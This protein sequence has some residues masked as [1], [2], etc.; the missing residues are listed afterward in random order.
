M[1]P[2]PTQYP[3]WIAAVVAAFGVC[4]IALGLVR[5]APPPGGDQHARAPS[6]QLLERHQRALA[7]LRTAGVTGKVAIAD[8]S[9]G[10]GISVTQH[11]EDGSVLMRIPE[12]MAL[13]TGRTRSCRDGNEEPATLDCQIERAVASAVSAKEATT[14]T[15]LIVLLVMERRRG[16]AGDF[17]EDSTTDVLATFPALPWQRDNGLF[18]IDEEEFRIFSTGTSM[19]GWRESAL[20]VV[21]IAHDFMI[22]K[23]PH[24]EEVKIDEVRWAYLMLQ[25]HAQWAEEEAPSGLELPPSVL[26]LL[27]L[28]LAR[29]TPEWQ[30][31][32][33]LRHNKEEGSY[34]VVAT[35]VMRPGDEVHYVDRRL[36]DASVLSFQGLWLT[37]RHRMRLTL[38]VSAAKKDPATLPVLQK[39]GCAAQPLYL[40]VMQQK[41]VDNQFMG[42]M[43]LLALAANATRL[44]RAEK[45]G[46]FDRWPVTGMVDQKTEAAATELG[47]NALQQVLSRLGSSSAQMR[48]RFGGDTAAARPTVHVREAETMIV[49]GLLKSMK[50]LQLVSSSEYLF[51]ALKEDG[52]RDNRARGRG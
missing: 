5:P 40:Y 44:Q 27:P 42:C 23:L 14:L 49:V 16:I 46:W 39:Y 38:N 47:I 18:A 32:V 26:F 22:D 50:E 45:K 24:L 52:G 8:F 2:A 41:S 25:S 19:A 11:V 48:Q 20:K 33:K 43:R 35:H 7:V 28:F 34:E 21:S 12:S 15:G 30:H 10:L 29:P 17:A 51:E 3:L 37:G 6:E 4:L 9:D 1:S 36:S 13:D 31:G